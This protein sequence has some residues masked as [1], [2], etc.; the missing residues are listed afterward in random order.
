MVLYCDKVRPLR[1]VVRT[2]R[3]LLRGVL[4]QLDD[5]SIEIAVTPASSPRLGPGSW[6]TLA[7][8]LTAR[9]WASSMLSTLRLIWAPVV[10]LSFAGYKAKCKYA[11]SVHEISACCPPVQG[12]SPPLS[13]GWRSTPNRG[14][15]PSNGPGWTRTVLLLQAVAPW[16]LRLLYLRVVSIDDREG[17]C[18]SARGSIWAARRFVR[19]E[20]TA[21]GQCGVPRRLRTAV[22]SGLE[23]MSSGGRRR[24]WVRQ[25]P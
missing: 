6:S 23:A 1:R 17:D 19:S 2:T 10:G 8:A 12:S 24:R 4:R 3:A 16:P 14:I 18:I 13:L 7:P 22:Q 21:E 25:W 9:S 5:V 20:R 11:P 15:A